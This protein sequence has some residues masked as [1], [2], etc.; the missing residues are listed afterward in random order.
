MLLESR[1]YYLLCKISYQRYKSYSNHLSNKLISSRL[2]LRHSSI[3][4]FVGFIFKTLRVFIKQEKFSLR[5]KLKP[6][7][8]IFD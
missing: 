3:N 6:L 7:K 5:Q 8:V 4:L 2:H 1:R